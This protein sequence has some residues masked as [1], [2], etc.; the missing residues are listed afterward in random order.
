VET[1]LEGKFSVAFPLALALL[2]RKVGLAQF[3]DEKVRDPR[4]V[5]LMKRVK[6]YTDLRL[7]ESGGNEVTARLKLHLKDGRVL[8]HLATLAKGS[9]QEWIS[10]E[11]LKEKFRE[12][13]AGALRS[14]RIEVLLDSLLRLG[15][16]KD[17]NS[18][19]ELVAGRS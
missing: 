15:Q 14:V 16:I 8:E 10:E 18:L 13:A 2:E 7:R 12:C 6:V 9:N 11:G 19:M 5:S 1:G 17:I 4:V 3:N